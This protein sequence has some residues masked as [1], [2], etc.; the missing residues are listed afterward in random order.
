MRPPSSSANGLALEARQTGS[1]SRVSAA[2]APSFDNDVDVQQCEYRRSV[3]RQ[4]P[5]VDDENEFNQQIVDRS[6]LSSGRRLK[7][8]R[9]AASYPGVSE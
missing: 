6:A 1:M 7:R 2:A 3:Q 8:H 9:L 5:L 4:P